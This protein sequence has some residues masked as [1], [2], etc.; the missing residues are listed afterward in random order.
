MAVFVAPPTVVSVKRLFLVL[1]PWLFAAVLHA[2]EAEY[3]Q[4]G[5]DIYDPKADGNELIANALKRAKAENK[6]VLLDFGAN[7]CPW[8]RKLH[9][10]FTTN[11]DVRERLERDYVVV[12]I[13]VNMRHGV[14]RNSD[15]NAKYGNPIKEGLPVLMVLDANGKVLTTQETG[16]L[17][18]DDH[19]DPR[20]VAAFLDAWSPTR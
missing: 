15:V 7:W 3:P 19:H 17:E 5:P 11:P 18:Q 8:C 12:L 6:H 2:A 13:D 9:E 4:Q 10:V 16:I 14:K 20:K 1:I